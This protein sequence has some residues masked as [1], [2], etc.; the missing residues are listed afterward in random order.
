MLIRDLCLLSQIALT[1][2]C[3]AAGGE[4]EKPLLALQHRETF[5][6]LNLHNKCIFYVKAN[7][8]DYLL[9]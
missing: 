7:Y 1:D 4:I 5:M 6:H 9:L 2:V 3:S 8:L